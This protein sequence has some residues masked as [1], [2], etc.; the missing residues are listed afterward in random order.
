MD[1]HRLRNHTFTSTRS[2]LSHRCSFQKNICEDLR[3]LTMLDCV[4]KNNHT[5][6]CVANPAYRI[7]N[8]A[9]VSCYIFNRFK[10][11]E[12]FDSSLTYAYL[13]L[14][15][16]P[17]CTQIILHKY[18]IISQTHQVLGRLIFNSIK[19]YNEIK[20][21]INENTTYI[22]N[23]ESYFNHTCLKLLL[24]VILYNLELLFC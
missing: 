20:I 19:H 7:Q 12:V 16:V 22:L 3:L 13:L 17:F 1:V 21:N 14:I 24:K 9:R 10:K 6:R 4:L 15:L 23:V 11:M 18:V 8:N 2:L 5:K